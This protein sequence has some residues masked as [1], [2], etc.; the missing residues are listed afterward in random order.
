MTLTSTDLLL[1]IHKVDYMLLFLFSE[2]DIIV[3]WTAPRTPHFCYLC[4][5]RST[6]QWDCMI[7]VLIWFYSYVHSSRVTK[8][9]VRLIVAFGVRL[10]V[11]VCVCWGGGGYSHFFLIRI[12]GPGIYRS[13]QKNI[14]NFKHPIFFLNFSNPQKYPSLKKRP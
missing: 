12:L 11:C 2:Y 1:S 13:P 9:L 6:I 7:C 10:P 5:Q 3:L 8:A 14:R 4:C